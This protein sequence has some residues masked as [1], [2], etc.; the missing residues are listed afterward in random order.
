MNDFWS[1]FVLGS[2]F[3][4]AI[5]GLDRLML[6][7]AMH[8]YL[9]RCERDR[10]EALREQMVLI[11]PQGGTGVVRP[12]PPPTVELPLP[13]GGS[14]TACNTGGSPPAPP[15]KRRTMWD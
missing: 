1:G 9:A 3:I 14:G 15:K 10:Q 4:I 12:A 7:I 8:R 13:Q 2:L 11:P 5:I 6:W